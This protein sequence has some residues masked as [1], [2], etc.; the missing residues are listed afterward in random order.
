MFRAADHTMSNVMAKVGL[1]DEKFHKLNKARLSKG[2]SDSL[3]LGMQKLAREDEE[4][5]LK[6]LEI[7]IDKH[8]LER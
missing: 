3:Y 6:A 5:F 2:I 8:G 1:W 4:P 7:R